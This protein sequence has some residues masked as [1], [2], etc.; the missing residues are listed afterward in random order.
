MRIHPMSRRVEFLDL[1]TEYC[2]EHSRAWSLFQKSSTSKPALPPSEPGNPIKDKAGAKAVASKEV[3]GKGKRGKKQA[4][5]VEKAHPD[6]DPSEPAV[7]AAG[8]PTEKPEPV[9]PEEKPKPEPE[10]PY[11]EKPTPPAKKQKTELDVVLTSASVAKKELCGV[12]MAVQNLL[13]QFER[14]GASWG[15]WAQPE[16]ATLKEHD[17]SLQTTLSEGGGFGNEWVEMEN[18]D[19]K[20]KYKNEPQVLTHKLRNLV[21]DLQPHI[22]EVNHQLRTIMAMKEARESLMVSIE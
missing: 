20:K 3:K 10:N 8:E 17:A 9:N 4:E 15:K 18:R 13:Q 6:N 19:L 21:T 16:I 7:A 14:T 1:T 22:K 5:E 11:P 12:V 2:E